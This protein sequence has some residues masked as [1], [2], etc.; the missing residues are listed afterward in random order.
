[1][2]IATNSSRLNIS[3][4]KDTKKTAEIFSR[5]I[6]KGD[7]V[8]F[9]GEVGVGKTTFIKYLINHLQKKNGEEVTEIPSPTF[10]ILNEYKLN[11]VEIIHL[12]L[13][14]LKN[15]EELENL[16]IFEDISNKILLIEWPEILKEK[17]VSTID[18]Y[19]KYDEDLNSR[20]LIIPSEYQYKFEDEIK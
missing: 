3:K 12:D 7:V 18:L 20:F 5:N 17:P 2:P 11:E 15:K 9:N 16:A 14:R 4:E 13:Y 10:S 1:M 19:F 8:F 6:Q